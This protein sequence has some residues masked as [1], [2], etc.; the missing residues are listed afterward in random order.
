MTY[1][2]A[3]LREYLQAVHNNAAHQ[4]RQDAV[5]EVLAAAI[6]CDDETATEVM[7]GLAEYLGHDYSDYTMNK[8]RKRAANIAQAAQ[9]KEPNK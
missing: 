1:T 5:T 4:T 6:V 3:Q 2:D 8:L 7:T 9:L